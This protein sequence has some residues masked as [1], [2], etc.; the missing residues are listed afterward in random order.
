MRIPDPGGKVVAKAGG[1]AVNIPGGEIYAAR[2]RG[3]ID[4]SEFVGP[5][6]DMK[7]GLH[8]TA[9]YHYSWDHVA[10]GAYHQLVGG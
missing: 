9:R 4:A 6:D 1:T 10:E 7:L 8:K 3:V 5:H 2:E